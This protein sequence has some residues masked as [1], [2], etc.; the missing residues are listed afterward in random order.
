MV[1]GPTKFVGPPFGN[2]S[3]PR[4]FTLFYHKAIRGGVEFFQNVVNKLFIFLS[5]QNIFSIS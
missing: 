5:S 4:L 2:W 1:R 3:D